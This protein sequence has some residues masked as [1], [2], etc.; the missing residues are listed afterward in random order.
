[1][2]MALQSE[3]GHDP[4][5]VEDIGYNSVSKGGATGGEGMQNTDYE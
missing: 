3:R 1:M 5:S 2:G 4:L